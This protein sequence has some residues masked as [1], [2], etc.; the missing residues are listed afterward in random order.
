MPLVR[1]LV[2]MTGLLSGII[3]SVMSAYQ[4]SD[5]TQQECEKIQKKFDERMKYR[6]PLGCY[7]K[8]ITPTPNQASSSSSET[9]LKCTL[10]NVQVNASWSIE[11]VVVT[12]K[13]SLDVVSYYES[14]PTSEPR[15][16][17]TTWNYT[18]LY[19]RTRLLGIKNGFRVDNSSS[20]DNRGNLYVYSNATDSV[21][22]IRCRLKLCPWTSDNNTK[23]P[24]AE[25]LQ[26]MHNVMQ[27]PDYDRPSD[28][29]GPR[30]D[31]HAT[32]TPPP[33]VTV[34]ALSVILTFLYVAAFII[35]A[36]L[37]GPSLCRRIITKESC[38]TFKPL[39]SN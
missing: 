21:D 2:L 32:K 25:L 27:L 13:S 11:W 24:N 4:I 37:Y 12:L 22:S 8:S 26:K 10:P 6:H 16:L 36:Y 31:Y 38:S 14:S 5:S 7:F 9:V 29:L 28:D 34:T 17:Y 1:R 33:N 19:L 35:L 30:Y 23:T 15:F 3:S 20:S 18:P 39:K